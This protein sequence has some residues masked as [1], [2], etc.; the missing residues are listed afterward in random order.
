MNINRIVVFIPKDSN[1]GGPECLHQFVGVAKRLDLP[2][3]IAYY[4]G[5]VE[6][7]GVVHFNKKYSKYVSNTLIREIQVHTLHPGDYLIFPEVEIPYL[8]PYKNYRIAIWW[9]SIDNALSPVRL[10]LA[11]SWTY[12]LYNGI[13]AQLL[14]IGTISNYKR[15]QL[16]YPL[17]STKLGLQGYDHF[18]QSYYAFEFFNGILP[19]RSLLGDFTDLP[20]DGFKEPTPY[21]E[22]QVLY[23]PKKGYEIMEW[24]IQQFPEI[25]WIPI[26]N[27]T[28]EEVTAL[29]VNSKVYVDFGNHPGKDRIPREAA[30]CGCIVLTNREGSAAFSE[31]VGLPDK[32]KFDKPLAEHAKIV[33]LIRDIFL[34]YPNQQLTY[35]ET[36]QNEYGAFQEQIKRALRPILSKHI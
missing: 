22:N 13:L 24:F 25:E 14:K 30:L 16:L 11:K 31:D 7:V 2:V 1:T 23:N 3:F 28:K 10:A 5:Y 18:C 21:K 20:L 19:R 4:T 32:Y 27:M 9:L 34:N 8:K 33:A 6:I 26:Q 12:R 17:I 15:L 36:V 35:Y 29:M